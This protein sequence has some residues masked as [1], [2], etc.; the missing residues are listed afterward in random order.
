MSATL[1]LPN[2][3]EIQQLSV[4][5]IDRLLNDQN[6]ARRKTLMEHMKALGKPVTE[7][8]K[9]QTPDR[10]AFILE[11]YAALGG[12]KAKAKAG[13]TVTAK[14]TPN[15]VTPIS[16]AKKASAPTASDDD[17]DGGAV[18]SAST[19]AVAGF[20]AS[21]LIAAI[22]E[23]VSEKFSVLEQEVAELRT[24]LS[25]VQKIG[26]DAHFIIRNALPTA[27]GLS[28][29]DVIEVGNANANFGICLVDVGGEDESGN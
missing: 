1:K 23:A 7:L 15:K 12:T 4:E 2:G 26:V 28:D 18:P 8:I 6:P 27:A 21:A 5:D 11:T 20:D 3:S 10:K 24:Q 29:D 17:D 22:V 9:M 16:A 14:A 13:G 25:E 19:Q